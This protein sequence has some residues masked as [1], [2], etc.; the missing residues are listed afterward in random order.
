[1]HCLYDPFKKAISIIWVLVI[2]N[3]LEHTVCES[4][5]DSQKLRKRQF[6]INVVDSRQI[7]LKLMTESV[8]CNLYSKRGK[9]PIQLPVWR[10]DCNIGLSTLTVLFSPTGRVVEAEKVDLYNTQV[11]R[12]SGDIVPYGGL[13]HVGRGGWDRGAAS[14]GRL[15][16]VWSSKLRVKLWLVHGIRGNTWLRSF[17]VCC[18]VCARE[19]LTNITKQKPT[20]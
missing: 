4:P 7:F 5:Q 17:V 14:V 15:L 11:I 20:S 16:H 6:H 1:M 2:A 3:Y 13:F 9:S 10:A 19:S 8:I 18:K 12:S